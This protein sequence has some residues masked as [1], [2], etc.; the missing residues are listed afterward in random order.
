MLLIVSFSAILL[1]TFAALA[2]ISYQTK[3]TQSQINEIVTGN[4]KKTRLLVEMQQAARERSLALYSMINIKDPFEYDEFRMKYQ[5]YAGEFIKARETLLSMPLSNTEKDLIDRQGELSRIAVPLQN[6]IIKF[7][8]KQRF[9][10]AI[11]ILINKS[12][13]AQNDV[14]SQIAKII[15]Y[16]SD[17]NEYIVSKLRGRL[18]YTII[19]IVVISVIILTLTIMT[20][21]YVIRRITSTEKQL[22]FEKE[23]AQITLHSIGDGVITVDKNYHIKTINPVAEMLADVQG[24]DVI[25]KNILSIYEGESAKQ[26]SEINNNLA[27]TRI[28][29]SL[30]D[31]TLTKMMGRSLRLN[32]LLHLL[33]IRI[34]MCSAQLLFYVM[35]PKSAQWKSVLA[36]RHHMTPLQ[37]S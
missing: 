7:I 8:D 12:I 26:R 14:L 3:T 28:Q 13:P 25:G 21:S 36:T 11:N 32:I 18:N 31:F 9:K 29:R 2:F 24:Q 16:Q 19:L 35:L 20:C 5:G 15:D 6:S 37:V 10:D 1:V 23:L 34:K 4:N 30:F 22:F 27:G 17:N 33:S